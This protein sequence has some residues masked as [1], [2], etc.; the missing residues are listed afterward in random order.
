MV[1]RDI[2]FAAALVGPIYQFGPCMLPKGDY[3]ASAQAQTWFATCVQSAAQA[4]HAA[5]PA[6]PQV[7]APP[8]PAP[9]PTQSDWAQTV[10][11]GAH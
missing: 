1:R 11:G 8:P 6:M 3:D 2:L 7:N 4:M 5:A 9:A 10:M